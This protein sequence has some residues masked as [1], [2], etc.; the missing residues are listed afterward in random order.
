MV[1]Y[2]QSTVVDTTYKGKAKTF[3]STNH[4]SEFDSLFTTS[5]S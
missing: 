2:S 3:Y 5:V 1:S 4:K